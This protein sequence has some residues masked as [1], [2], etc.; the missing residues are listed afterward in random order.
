MSWTHNFGPEPGCDVAD[1][2]EVVDAAIPGHRID[3]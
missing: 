1:V 3:P 2:L